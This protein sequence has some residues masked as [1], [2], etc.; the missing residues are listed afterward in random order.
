MF[1]GNLNVFDSISINSVSILNQLLKKKYEMDDN[2]KTRDLSS[3]IIEQLYRMQF[4]SYQYRKRDNEDYIVKRIFISKNQMIEEFYKYGCKNL[5]EEAFE[6]LKLFIDLIDNLP[7]FISFFSHGFVGSQRENLQQRIL[8][9]LEISEYLIFVR[10]IRC[11]E[12]FLDV[13]KKIEG[14]NKLD[15]FPLIS[16]LFDILEEYLS[17]FDL[18]VFYTKNILDLLWKISRKYKRIDYFKDFITFSNEGKYFVKP[19]YNNYVAVYYFING[20][21]TDRMELGDDGFEICLKNTR[22]Y[23]ENS[24]SIGGIKIPK[25]NNAYLRKYQKLYGEVLYFVIKNGKSNLVPYYLKDL[26]DFASNISEI[27]SDTQK[28]IVELFYDLLVKVSDIESRDKV[29]SIIYTF[30]YII[31]KWDEA[32]SISSNLL[33]D[34]RAKIYSVIS[35][36]VNS[37]SNYATDVFDLTDLFFVQK[38]NKDVLNCV[39]KNLKDSL[40]DDCECVFKIGLLG[41][42]YSNDDIIKK[43]SN[44]IGWELLESVQK[45]S[46]NTVKTIYNK[47]VI[48]LYRTLFNLNYNSNTIIFV[49]T[50]F[51]V[52]FA[53]CL[54]CKPQ[55]DE[56][57]FANTEIT[58]RLKKNEIEFI[59]LSS[60]LRKNDEW[61]NLG[62]YGNGL[63][64]LQ[65]LIS[66]K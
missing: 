28:I 5:I 49:S 21:E 37:L 26:C 29:T 66:K 62:N 43:V 20:L 6:N 19:S 53:Y 2:D 22:C 63:K 14:E 50:L 47:F 39:V 57:K 24:K 10:G 61:D 15:S 54:G 41:I 3:K 44:F 33:K 35:F 55:S 64:K 65:E 8:Q 56:Y 34:I 51:V 25:L 11:D 59:N 36:F 52:I 46:I 31:S 23:I 1:S 27:D 48:P 12:L 17:V 18:D 9:I 40:V 16:K 58:M 7:N 45:C 42:E 13:L 60:I 38:E 30:Q 4:Q 32:K